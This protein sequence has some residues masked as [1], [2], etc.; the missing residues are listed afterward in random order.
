MGVTSEIGAGETMKPRQIPKPLQPRLARLR[1]GTATA[2][3]RKVCRTVLHLLVTSMH[4]GD[5]VGGVSHPKARAKMRE[6]RD[7]AAMVGGLGL[8]A[9]YDCTGAIRMMCDIADRLRAQDG[10]V[11]P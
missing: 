7:F 3:D 6:V 10:S 5:I 2:I 4:P 11:K 8:M 1:R 9:L